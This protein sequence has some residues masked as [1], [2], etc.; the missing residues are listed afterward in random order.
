MDEETALRLL[1]R[2]KFAARKYWRSEEVDDVAQ[3]VIA[4]YLKNPESK[5]TI[6][7]AVLDHLRKNGRRTRA[8]AL[9]VF[10]PDC[11]SAAEQ[12]QTSSISDESRSSREHLSIFEP[13][14]YDLK[15][16]D[17]CIAILY[18]VWGLNE[19]EIGHCF[20]VSQSR[21]SQRL[22]GIQARISKCLAKGESGEISQIE[23]R[24]QS[25][26]ARHTGRPHEF[27]S[28]LA[29]LQEK[30]RDLESRLGILATN[31]MAQSQSAQVESNNEARFDEWLT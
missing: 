25:P 2:A 30:A 4:A 19:E 18:F 6:N 1:R 10:L 27:A 16:T 11:L 23:P 7:Q 24:V 12:D 29:S 3:E 21:I 5:Q 14:L 9:R 13:Y 17:R 26:S 28:R 15:E 22:I 8:G 20:G 31:Q